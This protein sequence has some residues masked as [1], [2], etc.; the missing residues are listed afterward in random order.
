MAEAKSQ[1]AALRDAQLGLDDSR[2]VP[3]TAI[4][5]LLHV[6]LGVAPHQLDRVRRQRELVRIV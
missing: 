2:A 3:G 1:S 6:G 4:D 5:H